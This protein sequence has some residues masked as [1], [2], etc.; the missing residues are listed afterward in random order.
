MHKQ[1]LIKIS[2]KEKMGLKKMLL[3][4][5]AELLFKLLFQQL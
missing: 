2:H 1:S 5:K 3:T 4:V